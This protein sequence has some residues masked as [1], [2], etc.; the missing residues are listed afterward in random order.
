[1]T[2]YEKIKNMNIDEMTKYF[3]D[4]IQCDNCLA[5]EVCDRVNDS[6]NNDLVMMS[7]QERFKM[8]LEQ[9]EEE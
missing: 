8:W 9:E 2:N 3:Y 7:C 1:M 6:D 5:G 4:H